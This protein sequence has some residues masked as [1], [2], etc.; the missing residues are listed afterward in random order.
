MKSP[1]Q[2]HLTRLASGSPPR[3]Y[4]S[5]SKS[6]VPSDQWRLYRTPYSPPLLYKYILTRAH[7]R[8]QPKRH[9]SQFSSFGMAHCWLTDRQT[10]RQ[11]DQNIQTFSVITRARCVGFFCNYCRGNVLHTWPVKGC[12]KSEKVWRVAAMTLGVSLSQLKVCKVQLIQR[13]LKLQ[14][15][16]STHTLVQHLKSCLPQSHC[17]RWEEIYRSRMQMQMSHSHQW[18]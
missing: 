16:S 17:H 7:P 9:L 6:A 15:H 18:Q 8:T 12:L 10:D 11:T 5:V 3:T 13:L 2:E 4:Q 1:P 14:K